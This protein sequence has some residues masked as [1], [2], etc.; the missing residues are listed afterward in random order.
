MLL[1]R[2]FNRHVELQVVDELNWSPKLGLVDVVVVVIVFEDD[3]LPGFV[4]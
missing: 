3:C 2:R 4:Y 1:R